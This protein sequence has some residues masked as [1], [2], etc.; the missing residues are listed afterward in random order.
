MSGTQGPGAPSPDR[1]APVSG[2]PVPGVPVPGAA[3][4][5]ASGGPEPMPA[6]V[7]PASVIVVSRHRTDALLRVLAA[8]DQQDHTRFEVIVVAD[9][10]AA[11]AVRASGRILKLVPF[12]AANIAAARNAGLAL[13]SAPV[14]AFVDDDAV[15]EPT[16]LSRLA[17]PFADDRV[18][19]A[20]GH[21][22][23]RSGLAWQWRTGLIGADGFDAPFDPAREAAVPSC[24]D[25]AAGT[26]LHPGSARRAVK[27][28]GTCCAFRRDALL[29]IGGFDPAYR[30]YL[31]EADVNLRLAARGGL[32]AAVPGAVVHHG[33]LASARRRMD[34]TPTDLADIGAGIAAFL[35]RHAPR[36][37]EARS[38]HVAAQRRRLLRLMVRG[39]LEPHDVARLMATLHRG[40]DADRPAPA[41]LAPIRPTPLPLIP[42]P[43]TGPRPG[44]VIA[45]PARDRARLEAEARAARAAGAVVSLFILSRGIR[46]HRVLF[47]ADGI[48]RQEG[49]RFGRSDREGPRIV[50]EDRATRLAREVA[51]IAAYRPVGA[52]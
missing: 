13:A 22:L 36:A 27:T 33:Y 9:P 12:D 29:A 25:M 47:G 7:I 8:L 39:A 35:A 5:T 6:G 50:L 43:G 3:S 31:D 24:T 17:A 38:R 37:A 16:W 15:P 34:R 30:F 2:V 1:A 23:G 40:L 32:T 21:V 11:A 52:A 49:G 20:G 45:G 51:R 46:P 44:R 42:C 19:Q 41:T 14:V 18:V 4:G 26:S 48:W 28:Q 10:A